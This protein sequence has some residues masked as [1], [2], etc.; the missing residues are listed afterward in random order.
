M[1]QDRF[2]ILQKELTRLWNTNGELYEI[3]RVEHEIL[4][5]I[6]ENLKIHNYELM[7]L[8]LSISPQEIFY[9]AD[10]LN[11]LRKIQLIL[12]FDLFKEL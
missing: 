1:C 8:I 5:I 6:I 10:N 12:G 4:D 3:E 7:V 11:L 2:H 9:D